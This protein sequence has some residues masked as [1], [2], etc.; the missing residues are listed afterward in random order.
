MPDQSVDPRTGTPFGPVLPDTTAEEFEAVLSAAHAAFGPWSTLSRFE[1]AQALN[2]A[3]DALDAAADVLVPLADQESGLGVPRLTGELARTT[4]QLRSFAD[5]IEDLDYLGIIIDEVNSEPLPVGHPDMRRMLVPLGP[6]GVFGAS[7]FPFAFSVAGGD[8]ASALAA[9]CPVVVKAHPGHPQLSQAVADI[10]RDAL[11]SAGAPDGVFGLVRG[12]D[13]GKNLVTDPRIKAVGFTGSQKAG[14]ALFDLAVGRPEPIPFYGELGS[15][16][17]VFVSPEA[18]KR[19]SLPADY[20]DSLLLGVGQFCT[21]PGVIVVPADSAIVSRIAAALAERS[22]GHLLNAG[23][24]DLFNHHVA[25]L[26]AKPGVTE[27]ATAV[28]EQPGFYAN[29]SL[30]AT[31]V[32]DVLA[33][34]S[35]VEVECF[36]PAGLVVTYDSVDEVVALAKVYPGSLVACLHAEEDE[37]F[38]ATVLPMLAGFAGRLVWNGW[39]TGVAV[40]R[41]QQHGGP[42]PSATTSMH[43]SVGATAIRRFLRPIAY[44]S[45]PKSL[46]PR[47]LH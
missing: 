25:E 21:N 26:N 43:T 20:L 39:P 34:P 10:V 45:V 47:E 42:Y 14:R 44:Q 4:F 16:N 22:G 8:S 9:G 46:L 36:G 28:A 12:F 35:I 15:V 27:L 30:S 5:E 7:N 6:V 23:V 31:H 40:T 37:D 19:D 41:A 18:A 38:A 11:V 2:V 17:P 33:D 32:A 13:A 24:R 29:P 1:R 3:A